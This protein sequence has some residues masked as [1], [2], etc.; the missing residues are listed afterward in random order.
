[1]DPE[2][3]WQK[4]LRERGGLR[5]RYKKLKKA[6]LLTNKYKTEEDFQKFAEAHDPRFFK[7]LEARR[8]DDQGS[9]QYTFCQY[10]K[11]LQHYPPG[12]PGSS[13]SGTPPPETKEQKLI[14]T[15]FLENQNH[16]TKKPTLKSPD[17]SASAPPRPRILSII[18]LRKRY[19]IVNPRSL[20]NLDENPLALGL[21]DQVILDANIFGHLKH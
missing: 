14:E 2:S 16:N 11:G 7:R 3:E 10:Q 13:R 6:Y 20:V 15:K 19:V 21:D 4:T 18:P 12:T 8:G 5:L 1:M 9:P 17:V